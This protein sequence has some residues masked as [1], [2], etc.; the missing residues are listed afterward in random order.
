MNAKTDKFKKKNYF[1][2]FPKNRN[3]YFLGSYAKI[4]D[5]ENSNFEDPEY[6]VFTLKQCFLFEYYLSIYLI[7]KKNLIIH[8]LCYYGK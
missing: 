4:K 6:I 5:F 1:I 7:H 8:Y 2:E 3:F